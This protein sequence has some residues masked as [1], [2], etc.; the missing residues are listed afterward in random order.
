MKLVLLVFLAYHLLNVRY[1]I[2]TFQL[3]ESHKS[4]GNPCFRC[5]KVPKNCVTLCSQLYFP[6]M[7]GAPSKVFN[8]VQDLPSLKG[9]VVLVTGSRSVNP[10]GVENSSQY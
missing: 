9:K 6:K 1:V 8:P 2:V 7:G 3:R 5:V 10:S 4:F